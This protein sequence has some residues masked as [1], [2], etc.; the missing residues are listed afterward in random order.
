MVPVIDVVQKDVIE[1]PDLI[2]D[3]IERPNGEPANICRAGSIRRRKNRRA[4]EFIAKFRSQSERIIADSVDSARHAGNDLKNSFQHSGKKTN[5]ID[6]VIQIGIAQ[7]DLFGRT[8]G[9]NHSF[10]HIFRHNRAGCDDGPTRN[11]DAR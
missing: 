8:T 7:A 4:L 10:P 6:L 3:C 5:I 9:D 1:F 2:A 11:R